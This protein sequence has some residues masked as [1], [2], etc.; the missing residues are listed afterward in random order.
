MCRNETM[1]WKKKE[2]LGIKVTQVNNFRALI[3]I[4]KSDRMKIKRIRNLVALRKGVHKVINEST[5][6]RC[7]DTE[8]I[9]ESRME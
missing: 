3:R 6:R 7:D 8:K 9:N 5:T 4:V 2:R 1:V